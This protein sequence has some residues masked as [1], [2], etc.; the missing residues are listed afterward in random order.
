[1][2]R[3]VATVQA[4]YHSPL[5][6]YLKIVRIFQESLGD[7]KNRE[8]WRKSVTEFYLLTNARKRRIWL[9]VTSG[10]GMFYL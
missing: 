9:S 1:M 7:E 4:I 3:I 10:K 5:H 6:Q 8:E 2:L